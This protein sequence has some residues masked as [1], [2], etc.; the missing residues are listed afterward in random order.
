MSK[1][2]SKGQILKKFAR[3]PVTD[4]AIAIGRPA[5]KREP[6]LRRYLAGDPAYSFA[7]IRIAAHAIYGVK[8]PLADLPRETWEQI[9]VLIKQKARPHEL[10]LN[11][12][13]AKLLVKLVSSRTFDAYPYQKQFIQVGAGRIVPIEL[14]YYLVESD[15][16]VFQYLQPRAEPAF[17]DRTSLV[18]MSLVKMAY[19][20]GD[21]SDAHIEIADLSAIEAHGPRMPR[22]RQFEHSELLTADDLNAE[23][24]DVYAIMKRLYEEA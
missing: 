18:L 20:F 6:F 23:I 21:Y 16:L 2:L 4:L 14:S 3:F 12:K 13:A 15:R 1:K 7:A 22:F 24:S 19:A 11:I 17:D 8:L 10:E 5:A 9:E